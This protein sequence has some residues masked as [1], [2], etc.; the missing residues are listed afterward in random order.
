MSITD[1][2]RG[3]SS[4]EL[5]IKEDHSHQYINMRGATTMCWWLDDLCFTKLDEAISHVKEQLE[6]E[7]DDALK[8]LSS[9]P[10]KYN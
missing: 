10:K 9:L 8:F 3:C 5:P 1:Y 2:C 7:I 4:H 6:C